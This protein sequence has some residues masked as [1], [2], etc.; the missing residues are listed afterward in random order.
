M[1]SQ[2]TYII[3]LFV[4]NPAMGAVYVLCL[5]CAMCIAI[6]FHEWAHAYVAYKLGDPTAK[7][8]GRMTIDPTKHI[9][10]LGALMF[11]LFGF[12]WAKPVIVNPNNLKNYRRDD[13]LISL[14]GVTMNL[15]ISFVTYGIL[16]LVNIKAWWLNFLLSLICNMNMSF[17]IFN[18]LPVPPLDGFHVATSLFHGKNYKVVNFLQQYGYVILL[19]LMF[20][21][22]ING[23][24]ILSFV[25][26][27]VGNFLFRLFGMF[28]G[29]FV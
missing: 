20:I 28:F 10:P 17:A 14:A 4:E 19:A 7:N 21:P 16:F 24:S 2:L 13:A 26:T 1:F 22:I 25:L 11:V 29:L 5:L 9:D 27:K 18:I 6:S 23:T 12:G 3:N 15:L 8:L